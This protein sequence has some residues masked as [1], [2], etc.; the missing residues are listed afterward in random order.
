MRETTSILFAVI[1]SLLVACSS[2]DPATVIELDTMPTVTPRIV[3]VTP[4]R[5][6]TP[7]PTITM[8]TDAPTALP[9]QAAS[10]IPDFSEQ[11]AQCTATLISLYTEASEACLGEPSG[12]FCN[13]GLPPNATA[14]GNVATVNSSMALQGSLVPI[15]VVASVET[16]HLLSNN[17]GGVMWVR[18]P[19]PIDINAL[20]L[21]K[22]RLTDITPSDSNL[23]DWQSISVVTDETAPNTSC[24]IQPHSTFVA[25]GPWGASTNIAI[26]GV[27]VE[28]TGSI[29]VQTRDTETIFIAIEGQATLNI[30]GQRRLLIA[31]QQLRVQYPDDNFLQPSGVPGEATLLDY[32]Y[33][34]NLP[35]PLLDRPILLPQ[36]SVVETDGN[37]NLRAE[38]SVSSQLLAEVPDGQIMSIIAMN[39]ERTWYHVRL[40]NGETGWMRADLVVGDVGE[41]SMTYDATPLPP[42]RYGD[43][44]HVAMVIA[45]T[46][47]NLR[48]DPDVQFDV[49]ETL[50]EGTIV[51]ILAR[52]PYS[53]YVKVDTGA[54]IGWLA[55][56]TVETTTVI[57]FLPIDYEVR[58][59]PGPTPTP[60]FAFGGGHAYP[61]PRAGN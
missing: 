25:Q 18:L 6:A 21:G 13:G 35:V 55:L 43:A 60:Y 9:A 36:P 32:E 50:P 12:F 59:P 45:P 48:V 16:P 52:S 28:L 54:E 11:L 2:Q 22:V 27:S 38:P 5:E 30:F 57:Q 61:D 14:R 44:S 53:A 56:I 42:E 10:S 15:D 20:I 34:E 51:E 23:P 3:Y 19:D 40:P 24:A 39:Q 46:G 29:A 41:I 37:V 1:A 49:L 31:G 4:T 58:L 8:A 26:N 7:I 33:I 47:A 17:S